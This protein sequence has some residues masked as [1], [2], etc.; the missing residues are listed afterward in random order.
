ML[1]V[2]G[3][4]LDDKSMMSQIRKD[5]FKQLKVPKNTLRILFK[6]RF[7]G[8]HGDDFPRNLKT[9]RFTYNIITFKR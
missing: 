7:I 4:M 8:L 3:E 1:K 6:D 2:T 9:I 5:S